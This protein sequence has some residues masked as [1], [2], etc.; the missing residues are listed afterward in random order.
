M[1]PKFNRQ[2]QQNGKIHYLVCLFAQPGLLILTSIFQHRTN[3]VSL[4]LTFNVFAGASAQAGLGISVSVGN[5][6]VPAP[7]ASSF[8]LLLLFV[9]FNI[10]DA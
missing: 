10:Q 5:G 2:R 6:G 4:F 1:G 7:S 9:T 3:L 8:S